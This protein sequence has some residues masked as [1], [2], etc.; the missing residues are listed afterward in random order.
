M[1]NLVGG[2]VQQGIRATKMQ[3]EWR[4]APCSSILTKKVILNTATTI[5]VSSKKSS[6]GKNNLE[7]TALAPIPWKHC[8]LTNISCLYKEKDHQQKPLALKMLNGKAFSRGSCFHKRT[9][10]KEAFIQNEL[11]SS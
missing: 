11:L 2:T 9:E 4:N 8:P 5:R 6:L 10:K 7:L 3:S 1:G